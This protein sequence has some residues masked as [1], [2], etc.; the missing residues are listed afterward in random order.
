MVNAAYIKSQL[1]TNVESNVMMGRYN[2]W[3]LPGFLSLNS[4]P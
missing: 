1:N 2:H 3:L 4:I